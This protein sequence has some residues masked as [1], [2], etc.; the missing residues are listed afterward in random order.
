MQA[1]SLVFEGD[2]WLPM[3]PRVISTQ[4]G[5]AAVWQGAAAIIATVA[6]LRLRGGAQQHWTQARV[7]GLVLAIVPAFMG[8]AT[9]VEQWR[10]AAIGSDVVHVVA[11]G[12]WTGALS[13]LTLCALGMR[14]DPNGG[15]VLA[16]F[17]DRFSSL[18][19]RSVTALVATG[20]ISALL[21][22]RAFSDLTTTDYGTVLLS[23]LGLVFIALLLGYGHSITAGGQ[24]RISGV[25]RVLPT[26]LLEW[27]VLVAVLLVTGLLAGSP[28]P[29]TE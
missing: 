16:G 19:K 23:K 14:N 9:A 24:L 3:I 27:G 1:K 6:F 17:V 22:L 15:F 4:W 25:R 12:A 10:W 20:V 2:P 5:H 13:V 7:A 11:A 18:A 21:H 28:P 8:H 29:G 26:F